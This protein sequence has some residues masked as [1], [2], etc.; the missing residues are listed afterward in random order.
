[1]KVN[2]E[3][4]SKEVRLIDQDGQNL[5]V[6]DINKALKFAEEAAL[7]LGEINPNGNPPVCKLIDYGKVKYEESIKAKKVKRLN[8]KD[9]KEIRIRP[10]IGD[11]DLMTK[12]VQI[13]KFIEKGSSVK[14]TIVLKG[15]ETARPTAA[16]E[17]AMRVRGFIPE[18]D[19]SSEPKRNGKDVV[20]TLTK[21]PS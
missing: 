8:I 17:L 16:F 18:A 4:K 21:N 11:N 5:G 20:I 9:N 1:M 6:M 13:R 12:I 10:A 14:V 19:Q 15:R 2:K 3:I 7:D